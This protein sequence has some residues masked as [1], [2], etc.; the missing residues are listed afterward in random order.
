MSLR[1]YHHILYGQTQTF[2]IMDFQVKQTRAPHH[3]DLHNLRTK[4]FV[5]GSMNNPPIVPS[6]NAD[7]EGRSLPAHNA[8][9][10]PVELAQETESYNHK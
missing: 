5:H 2:V 9:D 10:I 3:Q 6:E 7:N 1:L 8:E 4:K